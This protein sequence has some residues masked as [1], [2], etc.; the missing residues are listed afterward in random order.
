MEINYVHHVIRDCTPK[1]ATL[2]VQIPTIPG[3]FQSSAKHGTSYGQT[4]KSLGIRSKL[5]QSFVHRL[6]NMLGEALQ[7]FALKTNLNFKGLLTDQAQPLSE[8][9]AC[10]ACSSVNS[11]CFLLAA[12]LRKVDT[13]QDSWP[14][15]PEGMTFTGYCF[16]WNLPAG[17]PL[18]WPLAD[19]SF[20]ASLTCFSQSLAASGTSAFRR[21][22]R[23][24][25]CACSSAS[26][27]W[28]HRQLHC[29][30]QPQ[31]SF[32]W[33]R[34]VTVSYCKQTFDGSCVNSRKGWDW[35]R[36]SCCWDELG[37]HFCF[38]YCAVLVLDVS[39]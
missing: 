36:G 22:G 15:L 18:T 10:K 6:C 28:S 27:G 20:L 30:Q 4:S 7:V 2:A 12:L 24:S 8:A 35:R 9:K 39:A 26:T 3:H 32:C 38:K 13:R 5:S 34:V 1:H 37:L 21:N 23:S 19:T 25:K 11:R 29:A 16:L 17:Q 14:I 33:S 31:S